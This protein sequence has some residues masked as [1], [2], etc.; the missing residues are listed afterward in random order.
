MATG[1]VSIAAQG[2]ALP[3][4]AEALFGINLVAY[5][6]LGVLTLLRA[7][8][9]PRL[10]FGELVDHRIGPGYFTAV[11]GSSL[12]GAQFLLIAHNEAAAAALLLVSVVLWTLLTYSVF[13]AFTIKRDKPSLADGLSS[14]WLVAVVATQSIAVL[15]TLI[16]REWPEPTR[17]GL[18][19]FALSMWLWGVMFYAW[20]IALI[21]YRYLFCPFEPNDL[22]PA[23]WIAM[24]AMAI[25]A[26]AGANLVEGATESPFLARLSPFVE[27]LTLLCWATGTWWIPLL[28]SLSAW[29]LRLEKAPPHYDP[30]VWSAVFPLGMYSEATRQMAA[31]LDLPFLNALSRPM[32]IV[33]VTA[34]TLAFVGLV[35]DLGRALTRQGG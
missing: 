27:G 25:S 31:A 15:T 34:W 5:S 17:T 22:D 6:A 1:I 18:N 30:S 28:L 32:F 4:L 35:W 12:I 8:I 19:C 7:T 13:T 21:F 29:R 2:L 16:A 24:G 33:A 10:L 20:L 11:A 23:S 3:A 26:L 9:Y 14:V